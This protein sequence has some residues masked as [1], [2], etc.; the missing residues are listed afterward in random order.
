MG[1]HHR[2]VYGQSALAFAL[3]RD[4]QRLPGQKIQDAIIQRAPFIFVYQ[5]TLNAVRL[6]MRTRHVNG[7]LIAAI[8]V[9]STA[10]CA[11][12]A[13]LLSHDDCHVRRPPL[14]FFAVASEVPPNSKAA[15]TTI[16]ADLVMLF[17][18][19]VLSPPDRQNVW[20]TRA[21]PGTLTGLP[22]DRARRRTAG[23]QHVIADSDGLYAPE[24]F[25]CLKSLEKFGFVL[26]TCNL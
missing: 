9:I 11:T 17:L 3:G 1:R 20:L 12:S 2:F 22:P 10:L 19:A 4:C 15:A 25:P 21:V 16:R 24:F 7:L 14:G 13:A 18:Q 8:L 26:P 23:T 6:L 5:R